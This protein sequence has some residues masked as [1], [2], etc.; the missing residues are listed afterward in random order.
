MWNTFDFGADEINLRA[1]SVGCPQESYPVAM[2]YAPSVHFCD[3][4]IATKA[5]SYLQNKNNRV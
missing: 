1:V 2:T 3:L 5:M 4:V